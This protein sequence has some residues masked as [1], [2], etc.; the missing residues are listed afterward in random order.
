MRGFTKLKSQSTNLSDPP[1]VPIHTSRT[2][3]L[4]PAFPEATQGVPVGLHADAVAVA[5][6]LGTEV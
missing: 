5:P 1:G 4:A 6:L 2:Q 3:G